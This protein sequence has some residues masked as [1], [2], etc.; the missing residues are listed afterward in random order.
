M[1]IVVVVFD[2]LRYDYLGY[3][4]NPWVMTKDFDRFAG[5]GVV[6]DKHYVSSFATIPARTDWFTGRFSF[7]F[8]G[9]Q[10]LREDVVVLAEVLREEGYLTQLI[11]DN[12]HMMRGRNHFD[13]GFEGACWVRGQ[14]GDMYLTRYNRLSAA[15]PADKTRVTPVRHGYRLVD[16]HRTTNA[17]WAWEEDRFVARTL[18]TASRWLEENYK[19]EKFF[20]WIDCFDV[21]EPWDPPE[22][23]VERYDPGYAGAAMLHPNY[24]PADIY[25]QEELQNMRAHYAGEVSMASRWF[26]RLLAKMEDIGIIDKTIIVLLSDHGIFLGEHNRTGKSNLWPTDRRIWPLYEEISHVPMVMRVPGVA[27]RRTSAVVQPPDLFPTLLEL[28]GLPVP[29]GLHGRSLVP[30]LRGEARTHR[31]V[32]V[33]GTH[34]PEGP[35]MRVTDGR[36]TYY[37]VGEVGEAELYDTELDPREERNLAGERVDLVRA[38][39]DELQSWEQDV[40]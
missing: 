16:I 8:H 26:G 4:G 6:F 34:R 5:E 2:T 24:G 9:W 37:P 33:S 29:R 28:V 30:V 13:R 7:P 21:H 23:W 35:L 14:E 10:P 17:D 19:A 32:A 38:L 39:A 12:P 40:R 25:T 15:M 31:P 1:H 18:R 11:V 22:Y 27:A 20:L 3:N 36:Y